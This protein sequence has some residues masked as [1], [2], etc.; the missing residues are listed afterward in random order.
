[1]VI[2]SQPFFSREVLDGRTEQS[3]LIGVRLRSGGKDYY[4]FLAEDGRYFMIAKRVV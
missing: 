3:E 1:M 2:N 4:A